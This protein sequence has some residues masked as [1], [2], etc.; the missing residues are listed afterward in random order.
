[1]PDT[2]HT[3]FLSDNALIYRYRQYQRQKEMVEEY[4]DVAQIPEE[5]WSRF[6]GNFDAEYADSPNLILMQ[7]MENFL[8][9]LEVPASEVPASDV[10]G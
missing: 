1:M 7:A 6:I 2:G 8:A 5:E 4:G 3:P 10:E 9:K